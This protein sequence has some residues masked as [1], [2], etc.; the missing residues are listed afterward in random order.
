VPCTIRTAVPTTRCT[1]PARGPYRDF[2]SER[3]PGAFRLSRGVKAV[4]P[5][6]QVRLPVVR[7]QGTTKA[8]RLPA[9]S[10]P[11]AKMPPASGA[12]YKKLH[13]HQLHVKP[14]PAPDWIGGPYRGMSLISV[15][16]AFATRH[17][18]C[19]QRPSSPGGPPVERGRDGPTR[20]RC[21]AAG[22]AS[23]ARTGRPGGGLRRANR[24]GPQPCD[25][26]GEL[27][28]SDLGRHGGHNEEIRHLRYALQ[29][30][31]RMR[32]LCP[33]PAHP[34][35]PAA[36]GSAPGP[37]RPARGRMPAGCL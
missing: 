22:E 5:P 25:S 20:A 12:D 36:C 19:S 33:G 21:A 34:P 1:R 10:T 23:V 16:T 9:A 11:I 3:S 28:M 2:L 26:I 27:I 29:P 15:A 35:A 14:R 24:A 13:D 32:A 7:F 6:P 17:G 18:R 31:G 4:P 8:P 30:S 37:V